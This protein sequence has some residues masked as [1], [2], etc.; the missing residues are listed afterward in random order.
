MIQDN[1]ERKIN[2]SSWAYCEKT[3]EYFPL[4]ERQYKKS[5]VSLF[6]KG[7][8]YLVYNF[9]QYRGGNHARNE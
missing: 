5:D 6:N 7:V 2:F 8:I 4:D 1:E 3:K 9:K